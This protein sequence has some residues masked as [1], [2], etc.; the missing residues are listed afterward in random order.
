MNSLKDFDFQNKKVLVRC[1]FNVPIKN[2]EILDDF[3]IQKALPTINYLKQNGAKIILLSHLGRPEESQKLKIRSQKYSLKPVAHK[4]EK[5]LR[6]KVKFLNECLG[7]KVKRKI[8]KMKKGQIILLENLRFEKGEVA[9]DERFA[10]ELAELAEFY[11][12]EAFGVS[13]RNHA[14]IVS[15][16]KLLPH[17]PGLLLGKEIEILQKLKENPLRP[18]VVIIGGI[19]ISS[20]VKVIESFLKNADHLL[21]GG[22]IA[23]VILRVKGI[24][25]G[26]PWPTEEVVQRIDKMNLTDTRIHLP[27]DVVVSPDET[28]EIYIRE[29][30]P[31]N[32]RKEESIFDIGPET[33]RSFTN[34]IKE[35]GTIVWVGP[36]GLAENKNFRKGSLGIAQ[37]MARN[38]QAFTLVGGGDTVSLLKEFNLRD[39]FSHVSSGGGSMLSFLAGEKLPGIEA[40]E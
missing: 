38:H 35:A 14:S 6:E 9:N 28:G 36:L 17:C 8:A 40:L 19:K 13:H 11:I 24:S 26:R 37:A 32:V 25:V 30:G 21:F 4:L 29:T 12:G 3:R 23:N 7:K 34:I 15:L 10:K 27:V 5:L 20:K 16:P 31:G 33:I 1:D 18:L 22:K 39:K 2:G